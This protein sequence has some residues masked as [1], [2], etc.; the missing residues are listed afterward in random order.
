MAD[1]ITSQAPSDAPIRADAAVSPVEQTRQL[2]LG[3][4]Y[5]ADLRLATVVHLALRLKRPLFLEGEPGTGKTEIARTMAS[6]LGR[7]LIR[8]QCY[9]GLDLAGAAYEWNYARQMLEIRLATPPAM[10]RPH[11][12]SVTASSSNAPCCRPSTRRSRCRRCC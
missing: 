3:Q 10:P 8:L 12:C 2:L 4:D 11:A 5:V 9:E 7:P 1:D 6:A